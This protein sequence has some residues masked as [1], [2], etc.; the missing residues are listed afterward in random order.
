[1]STWLTKVIWPKSG[2]FLRLNRRIKFLQKSKKNMVKNRKL[3]NKIMA[4]VMF[5]VVLSMILALFGGSL[6]STGR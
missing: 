4:V 1:M 6:L 3:L 5:V 2:R